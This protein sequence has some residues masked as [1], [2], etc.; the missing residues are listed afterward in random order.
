MARSSTTS[1]AS[2][3]SSGSTWTSNSRPQRVVVPFIYDPNNA[4]FASQWAV[5]LEIALYAKDPMR[6]FITTDHP[7]AGPFTRYPRVYSWLMMQE[8]P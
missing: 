1:T 7:N 4:V 5:G 2:T 6:C 8:G 3:T